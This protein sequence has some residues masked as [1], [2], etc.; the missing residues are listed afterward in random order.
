MK[1]NLGD[2]MKHYSRETVRA[3]ISVDRK[4]Q[5]E[6]NWS[7]EQCKMSEVAM[8]GSLVSSATEAGWSFSEGEADSEV[9]G[10]CWAQV[11]EGSEGRLEERTKPDSK[12]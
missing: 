9:R 6:P 1:Q 7:R 12:T 8:L 4:K 10:E 11:W 3:M 2:G 5:S